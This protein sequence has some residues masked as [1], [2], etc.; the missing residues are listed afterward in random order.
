[1]VVNGPPTQQESKLS[2]GG[3]WGWSHPVQQILVP[4]TPY[5]SQG[6]TQTSSGNAPSVRHDPALYNTD[7]YSQSV[8]PPAYAN[9]PN[10]KGVDFPVS[11][12]ISFRAT[13]VLTILSQQSSGEGAEGQNTSDIPYNPVR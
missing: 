11:S 12:I 8:P 4:M 6:L 7:Y 9:D 13:T 1:M 10:V 5:G 3:P 2:F